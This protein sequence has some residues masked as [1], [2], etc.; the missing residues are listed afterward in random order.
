MTRRSKDA[1]L[2]NQCARGVNAPARASI[3]FT[4]TNILSKLAALVF[5]PIFTRLLSTEEYGEYSLFTTALSLLIVIGS[6]ELPGSVLHRVLQSNRGQSQTALLYAN[7][8]TLFLSG[9][10]F[11]VFL[12]FNR[13]FRLLSFPH[14]CIALIVTLISSSLINLYNSA[15]KYR[16]R[17]GSTLISAAIQSLLAPLTA[18]L[19]IKSPWLTSTPRVSV[20]LTVAAALSGVAAVAFF[21]ITVTKAR[22]ERREARAARRSFNGGG[23][24][25]CK[26]YF[27]L[28]VPMLPYYVSVSVIAGAD[29]FFISH[30]FGSGSLAKYSVAHSL[31]TAIS[32][33]GTGILAALLPWLMRKIRTNNFFAIR[34]TLDELAVAYTLFI[35]CFLCI[36]DILL[37]FIAPKVYQ[38]SLPV[39]FAAA[40]SVLP[41]SF[42]QIASNASVAKE[43]LLGPVI[44]GAACA[45]LSVLANA[46]ILP[47]ASAAAAAIISAAS[48][49]LLSVLMLLYARKACGEWI[50]S[51]VK[52]FALETLSVASAAIIYAIQ[53]APILR[54]LI[55]VLLLAVLCVLLWRARGLVLEKR[56]DV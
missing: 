49:W 50:I 7:L 27:S 23:R 36:A 40:L 42:L 18:I 47:R 43:R 54:L 1:A 52:L 2:E 25:I 48:F 8:I 21:I 51:P 55:L 20:R 38:G 12:L 4:A 15:E 34:Q 5:T 33:V 13:A 53:G 26:K 32:A 6:F 19:L 22:A 56:A 46:F 14:S 39:V 30:Y 29:R 16:Y 3:A 24:N 9:L 31:G 44:F 45:A 10:S 28:A 41:L 11:G 35:I 37:S 17:C